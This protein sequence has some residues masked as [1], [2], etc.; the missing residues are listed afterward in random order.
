M[1]MAGC[2][3]NKDATA[4]KHLVIMGFAH[5]SVKAALCGHF[6]VIHGDMLAGKKLIRIHV[7]WISML[8]FCFSHMSLGL[9]IFV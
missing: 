8:V 9:A 6:K 2:M 3:V 4:R 7:G 5:G 1:N